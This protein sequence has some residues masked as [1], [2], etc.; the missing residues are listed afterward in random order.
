MT[1]IKFLTTSELENELELIRQSPRDA[2]RLVM[3]VRRPAQGQREVLQQGELDLAEGLVG[4]GWKLRG[5]P[6][7][8]DG[9]ADLEA[10]LTLMNARAI[11]LLAQAQERWLLAGDQL[12]V[13]LDLSVENLPPGSRLAIGPAAIE[14]TARPH[15]GCN[16]FQERFGRDAVLFV[17]SKAGK[18]LRLRGLNARVVQPG[19][20]HTGDTVQKCPTQASKA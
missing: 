8:P 1:D 12:F 9:S 20:I 11:Q 7:N 6:L 5:S 15:T 2:G 4:D 19:V 3:I 10:Q 16:L 18:E 14:V 17:N 13:D